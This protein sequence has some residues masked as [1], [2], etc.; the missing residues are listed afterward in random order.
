MKNLSKIILMFFFTMTLMS[1]QEEIIEIIEPTNE[2]SLKVDTKVASLIQRTAMKDGS[3]DNIIDGA[4][5]INVQLPVSVIVNDLE[6]IID[7]VSDFETIEAIF[8]AT[9]FD[10]DLLE[11]IFPITIITSNYEEFVVN[12]KEE[13]EQYTAA[14]LEKNAIDDDIECLDFVYPIQISVYD[15]SSQLLNTIAITDDA[16]FFKFIDHMEGYHVVEINFPI[17]VILFDGTERIIENM[18]ALELVIE[19]TDGLCDEDDDC[20]FDDD[21]CDECSQDD[22]IEM[23]LDCPLLIER[24][25]IN[26]EDLTEEYKYFSMHFFEDGTVK[27]IGVNAD[28]YGE[29]EIETTDEGIFLNVIV[30]N[31]PN[32]NFRW[33]LYELREDGRFDLRHGDNRMK[34]RKKCHTQKTEFLDNLQEGDWVIANYTVGANN[35]TEKYQGYELDFKGDGIVEAVLEDVVIQGT[36]QAFYDNNM[37][38]L[39]LSFGENQPLNQLNAEWYFMEMTDGRIVLKIMMDGT[40]NTTKLVLERL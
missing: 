5:C 12:S 7:E 2:A 13:F 36:Y 21:D 38:R 31:L 4:S 22:F 14:C 35:L 28:T 3:S 29:W 17:T 10:D 25:K 16:H 37:L 34:L 1:C 39:S 18:E 40:M 24:L 19:A 9:D 33:R 6:I 26:E 23:L 30:P 11:I 15:S 32:F 8:D 27:V 20:D